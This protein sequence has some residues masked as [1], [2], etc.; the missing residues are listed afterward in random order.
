[1]RT[2]ALVVVAS[3]FVTALVACEV[4]PDAPGWEKDGTTST[5]YDGAGGAPP[6]QI[7]TGATSPTVTAGSG[8][9]SAVGSSAMTTTGS[10]PIP[11][12]ASP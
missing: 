7:S 1:M 9:T 10:G 2:L 3:G 6:L 12:P 4:A 11:A 5:G 8:V